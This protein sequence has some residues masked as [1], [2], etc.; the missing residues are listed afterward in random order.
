[1]SP[2]SDEGGGPRLVHG[3]PAGSPAVD[4]I[5]REHDASLL[6]TGPGHRAGF[7][8][9]RRPGHPTASHRRVAS[10][11]LVVEV[12]IRARRAHRRFGYGEAPAGSK[13][14]DVDKPRRSG[15]THNG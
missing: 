8:E 7:A 10:H 4:L 13:A 2:L 1:M 6:G 14:M 12:G 5:G 11:V 15:R 9:P 3:N